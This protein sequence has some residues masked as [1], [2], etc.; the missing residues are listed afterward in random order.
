MT[1][2]P[3]DVFFLDMTAEKIVDSLS[4]LISSSGMLHF[5]IY[6]KHIFAS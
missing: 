2:T 4:T 3:T 1:S 6:N 5:L